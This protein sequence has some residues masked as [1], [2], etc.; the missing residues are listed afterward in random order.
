MSLRQ[1]VIDLVNSQ[2][3]NAGGEKY[4][5]WW[6][7]E[8]RVPWCQIFI[9]WI[10][11]KAGVPAAVYG[12]YENCQYAIDQMQKR[13]VWHE[14]GYRP[15]TGDVCYYDWGS[16]GGADHGGIVVAVNG[17]EITVREGNKSDAVGN[18]VI[19]YNSPKIVGYAS[20]D[21]ARA[22]DGGSDTGNGGSGNQN[23]SRY[24][25][26][27]EMIRRGS[28]GNDVRL[29]QELLDYHG[30]GLSADGIFG[31]L[32]ENAVREYQEANGLSA[33]GIAGPKTW[34]HILIR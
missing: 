27:V 28:R 30:Y 9:S 20:P 19:A 3:T 26:E 11:E 8:S 7:Y 13:G 32:T 10:M 1:K 6:G 23:G 12:K 22:E 31:V 24:T 5:R 16:D 21:Y 15:R 18:R 2:G 14:R 34:K 29:L 25:F 17:N 4:W 33:D